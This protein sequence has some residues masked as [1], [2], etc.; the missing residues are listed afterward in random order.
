ME[1]VY[2]RATKHKKDKIIDKVYLSSAI[3]RNKIFVLDV[4]LRICIIW[5]PPFVLFRDLEILNICGTLLNKSES[6]RNP[7]KVKVHFWGAK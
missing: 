4:C 1:V 2:K 3:R 6:L 5:L 7:Y